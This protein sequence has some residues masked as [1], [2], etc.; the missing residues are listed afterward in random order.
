MT[1]EEFELRTAAL[2]ALINSPEWTDY[3]V[4]MLQVFKDSAIVSITSSRAKD[5]TPSDDF[6]RGRLSVYDFLLVGLARQLA[7]AAAKA[8]ATVPEGDGLPDAKGDP[9]SEEAY[10]R[11][12]R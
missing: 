4:P 5:A 6:L 12:E 2:A 8:E 10:P 9:Y 3:F 7:E 11:P 1:S